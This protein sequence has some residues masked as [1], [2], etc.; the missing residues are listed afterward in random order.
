MT[1]PL[2]YYVRHGETDWNV[3]GRLQGW[4]DPVLNAHGR[5]QAA[6]CAD[7][8]R[9]LIERDGR[10]PA[11]YGYVASPLQRARQTA[12]IMRAALGLAPADYGVDLRLREIGFGEWE[13]LTFR[14]IRSRAPQALAARERDKWAFVPPGGESYA[15]VALRMRE[16]YEALGGNTVVVAHGGTARALIAVLGIAPP[17]EAPSIDIGQGVVYRF[18]DASMSRYG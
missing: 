16:W 14:E 17:A 10:S 2:I 1:R 8:L 4:H 9:D 3:E 12:E 15:Q 7:I 6:V 11:D 13:G 18:A 5:R